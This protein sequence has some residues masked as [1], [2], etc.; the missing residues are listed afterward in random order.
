[1]EGL[2]G[3]AGHPLGGRAAR[4][5]DLGRSFPGRPDL[6]SQYF[7][8]LTPGLTGAAAWHLSDR[9][10]AVARLRGNYLFYNVDRNMSLGY[11]ELL[12]GVEYALGN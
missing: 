9:F 12:L 3:W 11:A 1:M 6:P 4:I 10:A 5:P 8:T 7:F 2:P